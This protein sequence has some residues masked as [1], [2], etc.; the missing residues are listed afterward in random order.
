MA[1]V[2]GRIKDTTD[3]GWERVFREPISA[4]FVDENGV[5]HGISYSLELESRG[6][7]DTVLLAK[8][9]NPHQDII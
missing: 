8:Q 6:S 5:C 4:G 2:L 9:I 7:T 1:E 3:D